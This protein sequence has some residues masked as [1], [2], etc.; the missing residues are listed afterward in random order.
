M[1]RRDTIAALLALGAAAAPLGGRAQSN[2]AAQGRTLGVLAPISYQDA[3][4]LWLNVLRAELSSFGWLE[5]RNLVLETAFA[6]YRSERLPALAEQLVRKRVDVIWAVSGESA[7]AA[8]RATSTIPIVFVAVPWPVDTGLVDS[9]ARPGRNV[10]G[11]SS[12]SGIEVSTKRLEILKEIAPTATR[13]SWIL[14]ARHGGDRRRKGVSTSDPCSTRR[15]GGCGYDVRYHMV[16]KQADL[17]PAFADILQWHAQAIA[18]AG[19]AT[20]YAARERIADFALRHRLPSSCASSSN[21]DAGALY[22]YNSAGDLAANVKRSVEYVDRI[23]RGARP[24][25]LPVG[26]PDRYALVINLRTAN[27]L[28]L[29]IPPSLRLRADRVIE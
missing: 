1:N 26:R 5:G 6:D 4:P 29:P 25:E 23:F 7:V 19:S 12:Y 2:A 27:A 11:V 13:L 18:V 15:Q 3:G 24:S 9:F 10:T 22:S 16:G 21:V 14:D 8:A 28:G 20:T 17:D